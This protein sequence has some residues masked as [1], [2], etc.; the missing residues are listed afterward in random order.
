ME[1]TFVAID[2]S[3]K[4]E[5][6]DCGI[7]ELNDYLKKYA[8]QNH[9]KGI[10]KTFV[11]FSVDGNR[12]VIGYY[13]VSMDKIEFQSL[14]EGHRRGLPRYPVPAMLVG[15]TG[16]RSRYARERTGKGIADGLLSQSNS[17]IIGGGHICGES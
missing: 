4:R 15:E 1:W 3:A 12:E 9:N 2:G 8:R 5:N 7:T 16:S 17:P 13:S 6:F 14:P 11:A 10:A